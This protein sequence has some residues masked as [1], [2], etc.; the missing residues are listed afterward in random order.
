M[1]GVLDAEGRIV[2][3]VRSLDGVTAPHGTVANVPAGFLAGDV[4]WNGAAFV[5]ALGTLEARA[6]EAINGAA[7]RLVETAIDVRPVLQAFRDEKRRE[8]DA[9]LAAGDEREVTAE[10]FPFIVA[11][12]VA[13]GVQAEQVAAEIAAAVGEW[14]GAGAQVEAIRVA[15]RAAVRDATTRA[16][17]EAALAATLAAFQALG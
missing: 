5:D 15:G 10:A 3:V 16:G 17:I 2:Q 9:W 7:E 4:E 6:L 12:A 14:R 11:E 1:I 13:R 8:L